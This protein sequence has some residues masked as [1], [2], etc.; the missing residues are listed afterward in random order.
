MEVCICAAVRDA[1]GLIVRGQRHHNCLQAIYECKEIPA[2]PIEQGFIT[3][4]NRFVDRKLALRIQLEAGIP[5]KGGAYHNQL[6]SE[7]LY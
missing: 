2:K 3:S 1:D 4:H 5:S 6:Y 7:D